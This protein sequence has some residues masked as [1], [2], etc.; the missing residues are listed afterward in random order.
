MED[1]VAAHELVC[2][3]AGEKMSG[4]EDRE[5]FCGG[6]LEI[7]PLRILFKVSAYNTQRHI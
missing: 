6:V 1:N 2:G 5:S 3:L 4:V 7:R